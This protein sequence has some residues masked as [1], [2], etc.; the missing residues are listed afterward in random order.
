[1]FLKEMKAAK[2]KHVSILFTMDVQWLLLSSK[3]VLT[4]FTSIMISELTHGALW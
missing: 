4:S 1:M 2:E 3:D